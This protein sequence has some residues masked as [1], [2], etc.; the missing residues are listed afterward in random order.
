MCFQYIKNLTEKPE[1]Q[2]NGLRLIRNFINRFDGE[3]IYEEDLAKYP[4]QEL[5]PLEVALN[6]DKL[7]K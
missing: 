4:Q 1:L 6:P 5:R 2:L 3:H 7:T